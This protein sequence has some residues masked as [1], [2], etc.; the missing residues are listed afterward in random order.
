MKFRYLAVPAAAAAA[1]LAVAAAPA[2]AAAEKYPLVGP[3]ANIFC[4]DLTPAGEDISQTA[5]GFAIFNANKNKVSAVVSVKDAPPNTKFPIRLIQGGVGGGNDCFTVD[6]TLTTN[7]NGQGTLNV[8]EPPVGT[9][10]QVIIDTSVL[11]GT[12]TYR[13]TDIFVFAE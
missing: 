5:P 2:Q 12:P 6:G 3:A 4:N 1:V 13:A 9:R 7:D 10:A 11:T 8:A